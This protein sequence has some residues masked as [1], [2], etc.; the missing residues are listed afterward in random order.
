[1]SIGNIQQKSQSEYDLIINEYKNRYHIGISK[2]D[3]NNLIPNKLR[4][5]FTGSIYSSHKYI[6]LKNEILCKSSTI[7]INN[8]LIIS[9]ERQQMDFLNISYNSIDNSIKTILS[10][11]V[12]MKRNMKF[13]NKTQNFYMNM[14]DCQ[15]KYYKRNYFKIKSKA[16]EY[17]RFVNNESSLN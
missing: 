14:E 15:D 11:P 1:M 17:I 4:S 7:H 16:N 2:V 13:N 9:K 12:N 10:S 8:G 6:I 3:N 5:Q